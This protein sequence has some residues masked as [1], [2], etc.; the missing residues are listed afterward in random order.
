MTEK[1]FLKKYPRPWQFERTDRSGGGMLFDATGRALVYLKA[2]YVDG[3]PPVFCVM[4]ND[5]GNADIEGPALDER[6]ML[7]DILRGRFSK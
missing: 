7:I 6:D 4:E 1:E 2:F 3:E 5:Q